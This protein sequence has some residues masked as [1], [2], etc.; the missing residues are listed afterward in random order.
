MKELTK[1]EEIVMQG[2][3]ELNKGFVKDIIDYL[4]EPKPNY[5]TVSTITRILESKGF[6]AYK[7]YGNT[8]QYYP[9]ITKEEYAKYSLKKLSHNYFNNSLKKLVSNFTGQNNLEIKEVDEII[10]M[11]ENIKNKKNE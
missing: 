3:W 2:Y 1:A 5:S 10:E 6:L 9:I 7:K 11:L 4:P 8:F